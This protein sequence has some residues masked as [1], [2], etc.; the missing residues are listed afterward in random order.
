VARI[1]VEQIALSEARYEVLA[2]LA[3]L[4]DRD[5]ALGKMCRVWNECQERESYTLRAEVLDA[6]FFREQSGEL[7]VQSSFARR[8]RSGLFY[9]AGT[10]G[11]IEW[12]KKA[13][14][15]GRKYGKQGGR[16]KN[17]S[18]LSN[19]NPRGVARGYSQKT[20]PSPSPS[21]SQEQNPH[22]PPVRGA[23]PRSRWDVAIAEVREYEALSGSKA[24]DPAIRAA[25]KIIRAGKGDELVKA[26]ERYAHELTAKDTPRE[27]RIK[28]HNW[29]GRAARWTEYTG[30]EP[31]RPKTDGA[32][33][34]PKG[35]RP[36]PDERYAAA[37]WK[38]RDEGKSNDEAAKI[39]TQESA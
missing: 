19:D 39:A 31:A 33:R 8:L 10:R 18:G 9:I 2:K 35:A 24:N 27:F 36:E 26:R 20:P 29:F 37:Y 16:P 22:T 5:H 21:P 23:R 25:E 3:G 12:L 4:A 17:P 38:A 1:S 15:N 28:P 34:E 13:R 7:L 32:Y 14:A 6:I 30:P 11:R